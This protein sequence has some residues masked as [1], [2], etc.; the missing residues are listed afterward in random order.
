K[1]KEGVVHGVATVA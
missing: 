1:T